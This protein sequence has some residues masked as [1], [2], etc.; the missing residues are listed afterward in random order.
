MGNGDGTFNSA[1]NYNTGVHPR[2]VAIADLNN[3]NYPDLAV[4]NSDHDSVSIFFGNGDGFFS[5]PS[6]FATGDSPQSVAAADLNNDNNLDLITA[7]FWSDNVS[8]M[9]GNGD[10]TFNAPS[11]FA[12]LW[13]FPQQGFLDAVE[14]AGAVITVE[15]NATAQ[16]GQ[17]IRQQTGLSPTGAILKYDGRPL[18]AEDVI[19]G[20]QEFMGDANG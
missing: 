8:V 14:A 5:A 12:D 15:A 17:L 9:M 2:S 11:N 10:G 20:Y 1:F 6:D 4:A 18:T 3:D 19:D 16:F 13:P 7:N